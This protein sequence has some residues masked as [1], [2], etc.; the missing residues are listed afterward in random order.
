MTYE[1]T[2][3]TVYQIS[4]VA[5]IEI[6]S[7][8]VTVTIQEAQYKGSKTATMVVREKVKTPEA[9]IPAGLAII[10]TK[11]KLSTKTPDAKIYYTTNG[12]QPTI[13]SQQYT[14]PII[15][16]ADI[17]TV[18]AIAVKDGCYDSEVFI[19][20]LTPAP[21]Y[22]GNVNGDEKIDMLDAFKILKY[23]VKLQ[24]LTST[25]KSSADANKDGKVNILDALLIQR[26]AMFY[27]E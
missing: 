4:I 8:I 26:Y 3:G 15:I 23:D 22:D 5:P 24:E 13:L 7:Y 25:Q 21:L 17:K 2:N 20:A 6:G 9:N 12:D 16:D 1:G 10:A 18:K 19:L 11:L 14:N 27:S